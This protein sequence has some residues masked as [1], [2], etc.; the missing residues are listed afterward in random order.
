MQYFKEFVSNTLA[1][2]GNQHFFMTENELGVNTGR[3]FYKIFRSGA[4]RY[5]FLFS[6]II[7]S[8][9]SNGAISHSNL[10]C[11]S[12]DIKHASVG[13]SDS[14]N[15]TEMTDVK[16]ITTLTFGGKSEKTVM[17]GE[18]FATDAVELDM[19]EGQYICIELSFCG[20]MIPYH[21]ETQIP[22]FLW[23]DGEWIPSKFVP[24]PSMI[25]CNRNVEK[26]IAFFGDSI[27]QGIGVVPNSY[28]HWN[29]IV[30][31][32]LGGQYAYWNL[33]LGF[34]RADDAA[35]DGAWMFKVRQNDIAVVCFGVNDI[36]QGFSEAQIK[37]NL[38]KIVNRL[39]QSGIKVLLQT[40]PPFGYTDEKK[41]IWE[42]T[43][44]YIKTTLAGYCDA[45][46]DVVPILRESIECPQM[47]KYGGHPDAKGC[48][49]WAEL[50]YPV[51]KGVCKSSD[52]IIT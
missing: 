30:A 34:G 42:N 28:T 22:T 47:A 44:E 50:L 33:G 13:I 31:D 32:K 7:D 29:A 46:F 6:N 9:Y 2:S 21:E 19:K 15:F 16:K 40:I 14:C 41:V 25:G 26:R 37:N 52:K 51:L 38:F 10:V 43:N 11:S 12:W 1:G 5:S 4:Y 17:P 23:K 49:A 27:T 48:A 36:L 45:I 20:K 3:L 18:F 39:K 35:S 24:F 8:T